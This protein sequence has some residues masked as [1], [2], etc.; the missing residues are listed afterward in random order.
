MLQLSPDITTVLDAFASVFSNSVWINARILLIGAI[1]CIGKR[2][3]TS[4]LKVMGLAQQKEFSKYHRV[5]S[6]AKWNMLA[7]SKILLGL[8]IALVP[9]NEALVFAV[10][11][12]IERRKGNRIT[13]K[14]CYRD[15]VRSSKKKTVHCFGLKWISLMLMVKLPWSERKWAL[16]VLTTLA[17]SKKYDQAHNRPHKSSVDWTVQMIRLLRRWIPRR[18]IVLVADGGY[19]AVKLAL[20]CAGLPTAVT[21][22]CKMRLDAALYDPPPARRPGRKGRVPKKGKKQR[23]LAKRINDPSIQWTTIRVR[24]YDG[25]L[26][27]LEFFSGV[28]LWYTS[29]LAPVQIR[30][31]VIRDPKGT[32]R[33][34]A[35]LCTDIDAEP[36]QIV[37]W[38]IVRWNIEVTFEEL[39]A[40]LGV[41]TQRQW[42]DLAIARTTPVLFSLFSLVVLMANHM[43]KDGRLPIQ[44]HA[45]YQKSQATFSDA[46][47]IVRRDIWR[48]LYYANSSRRGESS[49]SGAAF[50]NILLQTVCYA[51]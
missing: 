40:H 27:T 30:W 1:L 15:A 48:S 32:L 51:S 46:I 8:L 31:V 29:G 39:R 9:G 5:L 35:L 20:C 23:S 21:L 2:T 49:I 14:S 45:W 50:L 6:R 22:V 41:E 12:H 34:E 47:A 43:I 36:R 7:G 28:S 42:S 18:V 17:T 37:A 33:T 19:A 25:K 16:P 44:K 26:R 13:K 10:D 4:S 38:Y 3:V 24:W 11:D